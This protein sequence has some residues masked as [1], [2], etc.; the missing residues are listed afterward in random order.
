MTK[1]V[2]KT[3]FVFLFVLQIVLVLVVAGFYLQWHL[4]LILERELGA[5]LEAI[6]GSVA[7]QLDAAL[8]MSLLPGDENTRTYRNLRHRLVEIQDATGVS[9]ITVF[10]LGQGH[11][12]DTDSLAMIGMPHAR[13][14]FDRQELSKVL[15]GTRISSV[16]F[17]GVDERLYKTGYAPLYLGPRVEA[18]VAVE[19]SAANLRAVREV[20]GRLLQVGIVAVVFAIVTAMFFSSQITSPLRK[21]QRAAERISRGEL[22]PA[23]EVHGSDE[24]A[25]LGKT[26]DEMRRSIL[27]RDERQKAMLAGVAHEIRNPLGGIELF[28]SMLAD[29]LLEEDAKQQAF[30]ILKEARNLKGIVQDF[31]DYAKPIVPKRVACSVI[32]CLSTAEMLLANE[33]EH[34]S[35][36]VERVSPNRKTADGDTQV[37]VDPQHL[38]QVFLNL[39]KNAIQAMPNGGT[40]CVDIEQMNNN[41]VVR[42]SDNGKGISETSVNKIFDP[43]FT[44]KE[45]GLGLGLSLVKNLIEENGGSIVLKSSGPTGTTF[46]ITLP[47]VKI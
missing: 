47:L 20:Q 16:L 3:R 12:V 34:N 1:S 18:I 39:T 32:E 13:Q 46:E 37:F 21:L 14:Q 40:I 8:A 36:H 27:H 7:T 43:F 26:M 4:R 45:Q 35:I 2:I 11:I 30:K 22:E 6:A 17:K 29:E 25:F 38:K 33:I 44:T 24:I 28:A 10:S 19:G 41:A 23:I 15:E 5:K 42:F 31:L 9:R